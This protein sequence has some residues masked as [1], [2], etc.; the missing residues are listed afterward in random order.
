LSFFCFHALLLDAVGPLDP[1]TTL[2]ADF[3]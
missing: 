3:S 1:N 2:V